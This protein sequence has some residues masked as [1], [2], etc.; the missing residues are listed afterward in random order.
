MGG[1]GGGGGGAA[2]VRGAPVERRLD[3]NCLALFSVANQSD[4]PARV[5]GSTSIHIVVT[6]KYTLARYAFS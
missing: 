6:R 1:G 3:I 4:I 5:L 2:R